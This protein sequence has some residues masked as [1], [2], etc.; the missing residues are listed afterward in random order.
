MTAEEFL[1]YVDG[2]SA[3]RDK[4]KARLSRARKCYLAYLKAFHCKSLA[5]LVYSA[6]LDGVNEFQGSLKACKD[7]DAGKISP[8]RVDEFY[9]DWLQAGNKESI[10]Q[11]G[12]SWGR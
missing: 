6:R 10:A 7:R 2:N 5:E 12:F 3:Y 9:E 11:C 1:E 8:V 4:G